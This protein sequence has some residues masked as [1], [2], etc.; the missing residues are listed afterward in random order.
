M[1]VKDTAG[2]LVSYRHEPYRVPDSSDSLIIVI[3]Y[4]VLNSDFGGQSR[5]LIVYF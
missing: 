4:R 2:M 5:S 3:L 1:Y